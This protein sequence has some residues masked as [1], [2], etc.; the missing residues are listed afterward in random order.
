MNKA[1]Q[2]QFFQ[3][4]QKRNENYMD[5]RDSFHKSVQ[6]TNEALANY[7]QEINSTV[8]QQDAKLIQVSHYKR[9]LKEQID[10]ARSEMGDKW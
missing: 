5:I 2:Q 3:I 7:K 1:E 8:M 4:S 9:Q 10:V 6:Q